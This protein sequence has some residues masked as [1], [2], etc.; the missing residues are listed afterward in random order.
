[1][2]IRGRNIDRFYAIWQDL[3]KS[4][5]WDDTSPLKEDGLPDTFLKPFHDNKVGGEWNSDKA[6]W[7]RESC[8]YSYP[9]LQ[10]WLPQ[11]QKNGK[12]DET[13]YRL[14]IK[15]KINDLYGTMPALALKPPKGVAFQSPIH[16]NARVMNDYVVFASYEKYDE[17]QQRWR[18]PK[19]TFFRR[20][21]LGGAP[22]T[23]HILLGPE[24]SARTE[25][26]VYSNEIGIIYNF[27]SALHTGNG[28]E[29][30][31][32]CAAQAADGA[33]A[34]GLLPLTSALIYLS[35]AQDGL[36]IDD[37]EKTLDWL[38]VNLSWKVTSVCICTARDRSFSPYTNAL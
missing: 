30:C 24:L 23:I 20:F 26:A 29:G 18:D 37:R 21:A 34:T 36:N 27:S 14:D 33:L 17:P 11:Y 38:K 19:L 28:S 5:W 6:R 9:E 8:G 2:L 3:H 10:P 1:M 16:D 22:F 12:F 7:C 13:L 32:N 35:A 4:L 31:A 25:P 15:F